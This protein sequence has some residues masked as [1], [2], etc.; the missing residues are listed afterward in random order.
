MLDKEQLTNALLASGDN[1]PVLSPDDWMLPTRINAAIVA[2]FTRNEL[3]PGAPNTEVL[4]DAM[5]LL[6]HPPHHL[7]FV[8][9]GL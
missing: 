8:E 1:T 3:E 5:K 6:A 7:V 4:R 9:D 2:L